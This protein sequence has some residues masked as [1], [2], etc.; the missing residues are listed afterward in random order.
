[1]HWYDRFRD[2]HTYF[3]GH[4]C[5]KNKPAKKKNMD[6]NVQSVLRNF[7]I[8]CF[9][10]SSTGPTAVNELRHVCMVRPAQMFSVWSVHPVYSLCA[11]VAIYRLCVYFSYLSLNRT[12]G[13]R[14][15]SKVWQNAH[16]AQALPKWVCLQRRPFHVVF[17]CRHCPWVGLVPSLFWTVML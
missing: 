16:Y 3:V 6:A 11:G 13:S 10:V 17:T 7:I 4:F 8:C 5:F 1:M 12:H 9:P 14:M 2:I 15:G